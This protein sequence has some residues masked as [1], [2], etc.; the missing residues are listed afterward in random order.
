F[1]QAEDGIRDY[2]VTGVQT[3][4]LPISLIV[5]LSDNGESLGEHGER[6]HGLFAYDATLR[7]PL[8]MFAAG[9]IR[10]GVF[11][12]TMRLVDIAP[13]IRS[14]ERSVGKEGRCRWGAY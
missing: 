1:F 4:A 13:T 14:E 6:T 9:R 5:I 7:V 8:V 3:C 12:E 10:P 2:K 11:R